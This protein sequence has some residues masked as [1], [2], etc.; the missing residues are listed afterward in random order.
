MAWQSENELLMHGTAW[1]DL[2]ETVLSG[3]NQPQNATAGFHG[4][5]NHAITM[6]E[7]TGER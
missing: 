4:G 2:E 7:R 3:E 5:N 1:M 6:T